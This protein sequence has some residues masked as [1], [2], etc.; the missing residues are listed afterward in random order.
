MFY[1]KRDTISFNMIK[2][3]SI[4]KIGV[5]PIVQSTTE[6]YGGSVNL[7]SYTLK[8]LGIECIYI[9]KNASD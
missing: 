7:F 9:D 3:A 8:R 4:V 6:I 1:W 5:I 2:K